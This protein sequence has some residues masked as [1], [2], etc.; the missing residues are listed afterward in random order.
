MSDKVKIFALGGLDEYGKN[1]YCVD[2][3]DDI[4]V[5]ECGIK[6]P[7]KSTPG[8]NFIIADYTYL[9][10]NKNRVKGIFIS[11]GHEDMMGGLGFLFTKAGLKTIQ[12]TDNSADEC[13]GVTLATI[14][15]YTP[16]EYYKNKENK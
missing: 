7:D 5:F 10:E 11:H 8:V 4:F 13:L 16:E 6:F 3:N 2:I 12:E 14:A 9:A 15:Q 1:L